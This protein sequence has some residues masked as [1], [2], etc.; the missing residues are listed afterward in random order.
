MSVNDKKLSDLDSAGTLTNA[1]LFGYIDGVNYKFPSSLFEAG[2]QVNTVDSVAGLTGTISDSALRTAINVED[3]ATA[4]QTG[5]EIKAAYEA[6]ADTNVF[7]DA[8]VSKLAG[9]EAGAQVNTVDSVNGQTGTVAL[10]ADD[11]DDSA[12]TNKFTTAGDISKLAGIEAGADVTDAANVT[13]AGALMDSEL[14]DEAAV[15]ALDQGVATTD[16]PEFAGLTVPSINGGPL[17]GFRNKIIN[18]D[19]DIWQRGTGTSATG[20]RYDSAD[21]WLIGAGSSTG[22][23][24]RQAHTLGQT[25]VP[26][27]PRYFARLA[28]TA[29]GSA[30]TRISQSVEDVRTLAGK[31]ITVTFWAKYN[32]DAPS[33]NLG[34]RLYQSFGTGGTPSGEVSHSVMDITLTN[35]WQKFTDTVT[36]GSL[37]GKTLGSN[38]DDHLRLRVHNATNETWDMD[39]SH[40]SVVEGD[41]TS[42]DDPFSPRHISQELALCQRYYSK[43]YAHDRFYADATAGWPTHYTPVQMRAAPTVTRSSAYNSNIASATVTVLDAYSWRTEVVASSAGMIQDDASYTCDAEL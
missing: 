20:S 2:A 37:A 39:I 26:G 5:A 16:T 13:A 28:I 14:T 30:F 38:G 41:A 29:T 22:S 3:G 17:G 21:R 31:L 24:S 35:S 36:L 43:L 25:D 34:V 11:I 40:V 1:F 10:D 6:E 32:A 18:G 7:N 33:G 8:A 9:I 19:F 42:E 12:T 15:K 23:L 27:N 4:D